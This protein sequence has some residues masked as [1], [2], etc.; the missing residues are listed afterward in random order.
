MSR[1]LDP[2]SIEVYWNRLINIID[3]AATTLLKTSFSSVVRDFHDFACALFDE[4]QLMLAHSTHTTPGLLGTLPPIA[5]NFATVYPPERLKPGDVLITNDVWLA[6]GHLIDITICTPIFY[7]NRI[8]AY[9]LCIVHHLN[10]GG[11]FA[12]IDSSDIYE[13][14]LSI[15]ISR[16]CKEGKINEEL[17]EIIRSN[18]RV[19]D[20]VIGDIWAQI[21]ANETQ[22]KLL[23]EFL[24]KEDLEDLR[25]LS[26]EIVS[27]S[28]KSM[29]EKIFNI[30]DNTF[31][32][33][34]VLPEVAQG[35]DPIHLKV[36]I[37]IRGSDIIID[38][39]GSS[40]QIEKALN[41]TYN[42]TL[43]YTVYPI[44]SLLD[45]NVPNNDGCLRPIKVLAPEGSIL[46]AQWPAATFGRSMI[47]H[48]MAALVTRTMSRLFQEQGIADSG[49]T[50]LLYLSLKGSTLSGKSYLAVSSHAGG[51]G[52]RSTKD[53]PS[54][55]PFPYNVS[56]IPVEINE[57]DV[58][59]YFKKKSLTC[60]SGGPGKYR[61]GCGQE[62]VFK[63]L[64]DPGVAKYGLT[65]SMRGGRLGVEVDGIWGGFKAPGKNVAKI[66]NKALK[67]INQAVTLHPGDEL[68][69]NFLGG[70]GY[71]SPLIRDPELVKNDVINGL[72]SRKNA[73]EIYKVAI[74][75]ATYE[76]DYQKTEVMR[77]A[78]ARE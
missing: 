64:D 59:I 21:N 53:G 32:S 75:L 69:I 24:K 78:M 9:A 25:E 23:I 15:P 77:K 76:I 37:T 68:S 44:K 18:V 45:P 6:S 62:V 60:D 22:S 40:S 61:G 50:S 17:F 7:R 56:N 49:S 13:E 10:V 43:S 51:F 47:A 3:G 19:P 29:R 2:I 42:Q 39:A 52:A 73:K 11:R 4:E 28:E 54:C 31:S 46:N 63:V 41:C 5:K 8:L 70:G 58:P 55:R 33:E 26:N 48:F 30:P 57:S 20:Q 27:R 1:K 65:V 34:M 35:V 71:G 67:Y 74:N 16:I 12:S 66:N 14:G 38:Y 72:V 36:K